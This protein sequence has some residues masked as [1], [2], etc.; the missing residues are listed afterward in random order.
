VAVTGYRI[1]R[2]TGAGCTT[3][4]QIATTT[5]A[6]TYA[7][8]GLVSATVYRYRVRA[9]DATSNLG[10]Y[11]PIAEAMTRDVTAPSAPTSLVGTPTSS[12]QVNLAWIASTDNVGVAEYRIERCQGSSCT[13]FTQIGIAT[14][15]AFT[16]TGRAPSTTYRYRVRAADAAGNLSGYSNI[17]TVTTPVGPDLTPPTAPGNLVAT[18]TSG[19]EITLSWTGSTDNVAVTAYQ[20]ERC[21]GAG[22][23][24]FS[25]IGTPTATTFN[26]TGLAVSTTYVY[27]VR[28]V[29]AAG[30]V[31]GYSAVASATTTNGT[32][33][34]L[35]PG[36]VAAYSFNENGGGIVADGSG[37]GNTGSISGAAWSSQGKFG[38]AL[39][40]NGT[41]SVVFINPSAT[42]NVSSAMTLEAWI[43]PTAAQGGWRTI[44]QREVDAFFLNASNNTGDLRPSGGGTLGGSVQ[45]VSGP[46]ASPVDAWTHV[47]LTYDGSMLRLYVNGTLASSLAAAGAIETNTKPLRIGGNSPYGEF[48]QGLIDEVRVYNRALSQAEI[49]NDL[50]TPLP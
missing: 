36:L 50:V 34:P 27:R 1:E 48:F 43:R 41:S 15:G 3:F 37:N 22:C 31:S 4:A 30:N 18:A 26:D 16:D 5:S 35:P 38:S 7:N 17:A 24:T 21:Q 39:A 47:A 10:A 9:I 13:T 46:T 45:W 28:A 14:T 25:Q 42:L 11:S 6:T 44:L 8:T 49:A 12:S 33:P 29:D 20:V 23:T 32:T 19:S 2:C 40:F